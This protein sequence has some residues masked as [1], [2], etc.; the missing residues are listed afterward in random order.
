MFGHLVDYHGFK[1]FLKPRKNRG[2]PWA[3]NQTLPALV[4][5]GLDPVACC[6][7]LQFSRATHSSPFRSHASWLAR[8]EPAYAQPQRARTR[9]IPLRNSSTTKERKHRHVGNAPPR[10]AGESTQRHDKPNATCDTIRSEARANLRALKPPKFCY[11]MMTSGGNATCERFYVAWPNPSSANMRA[12][13][14]YTPHRGRNG[15]C[16]ATDELICEGVEA[17]PAV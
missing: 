11:E 4:H 17:T 7:E 9:T 14:C 2:F 3:R 12:R 6:A 8:L 1:L 5:A 15:R 10:A 16:A 13:A